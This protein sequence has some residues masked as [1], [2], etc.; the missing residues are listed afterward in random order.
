MSPHLSRISTSFIR[1][2]FA[3][4]FFGG[5]GRKPTRKP[6]ETM[7]I[8]SLHRS[9]CVAREKQQMTNTSD[10]T[11][12]NRWGLCG[13][14][15]LLS[16]VSEQFLPKSNIP[17]YRIPS[18]P[19]HAWQSLT[20]GWTPQNFLASVYGGDRGKPHQLLLASTDCAQILSQCLSNAATR[21][22]SLIV[23]FCLSW[24]WESRVLNQ[25][26]LVWISLPFY[27]VW[28]WATHV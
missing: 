16:R 10:V 19:T 12:K 3:V 14:A 1:F 25:E 20:E 23:L 21:M 8:N 11:W 18:H 22:D 4:F 5:G 13:N 2:H 26:T 27:A 6:P 17:V 28:L 7:L 15:N 9:A 24:P